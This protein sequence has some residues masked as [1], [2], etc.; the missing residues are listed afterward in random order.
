M[1]DASLTH[2]YWGL[3]QPNVIQPLN[4]A[5]STVVEAAYYGYSAFTSFLWPLEPHWLEAHLE[6][7]THHAYQLGLIPPDEFKAFQPNL[8]HWLNEKALLGS[9]LLRVRITALPTPITNLADFEKSPIPT[10][11]VIQASSY[12]RPPFSKPLTLGLV[13]YTKALPHI[14]H[15]SLLEPLYLRRLARQQG[16]GE[17]LWV[18][19][20]GHITE[21]TTANVFFENTTGGCAQWVTPPLTQCLEGICRQQVIEEARLTG[22]PIIERPIAVEEIGTTLSRGFLTNSVQGKQPFACPHPLPWVVQP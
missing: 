18:N 14:K 8:S 17:V 20:D 4:N 11:W 2:S 5:P 6:R 15:G 7:V 1:P 12:Q 9:E 3:W 10:Q 21:A 16:L 19:G 22:K 13:R